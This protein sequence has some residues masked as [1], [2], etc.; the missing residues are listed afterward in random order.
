[1]PPVQHEL[2]RVP[3]RL[4]TQFLNALEHKVLGVVTR[5]GGQLAEPNL[6]KLCLELGKD[7]FYC[8]SVRSVLE[9]KDGVGAH[10]SIGGHHCGRSVVR[11]V[12]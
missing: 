3:D 10:L 11:H 4:F 2:D 5:A 12:V 7:Y 6:L 1:M 8:V 9:V